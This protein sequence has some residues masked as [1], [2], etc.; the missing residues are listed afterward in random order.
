M[1]VVEKVSESEVVVRNTAFKWTLAWAFFL[2]VLWIPAIFC[3]VVSQSTTEQGGQIVPVF[4]FSITLCT[5]GYMLA[6]SYTSSAMQ[7]YGK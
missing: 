1:A 7:W 4:L 2:T 5:C 3:L 6:A